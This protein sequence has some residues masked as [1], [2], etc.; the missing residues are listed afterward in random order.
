MGQY[1]LLHPRANSKL[2]ALLK[3][4]PMQSIFFCTSWEDLKVALQCFKHPQAVYVRFSHIAN[5]QPKFYVGSTSSF[6]LDREHSRYRKFLQVQQNK[7]VL[8]E[9][10]LRF[11][12]RFDNFWMWSVFPIYTNKSNFWA[13]EQALIQLWQPRLNTPFIYQF[14]NCRKGL[15]SRTKFSNSRQFGAFSLWRKLRW[16]STPHHLRRALHSPLFH[17]RVQLWEIIQDLGSNSVRRFHMEKRLRS[18]ETGAQGCY[19]IRRLANNLGEPQRSY[20][21][22]AIDRALT[23]WKAKRVRKPVPLRAPWLLAPNWTR[24][25]RQLLTAH[26]H[27]TKC[28]NTALQTPSTGIVFTKFPS[29]MDSLCNHKEAATKWADGEAPKCACGA[30]RQQASHHHQPDQ[31]LVLEGDNLHFEDGPYTSI[32]TGSLQ[33]KI[34]PPS[35]EI[36]ASLRLALRSWTT[37]NS[38]PSLPKTH[39]D[40][41]WHR[42]IHSHYNALHNHITHK[43]IV[44]FKR[45]FPDAIFHN[46][47]K[48]ATSL[49]IY[50]PVLYFQ[51]LTTTFAD[52]LVFRKLEESSSDIIEKTIAEINKQFGKSYPWALGAGRDLPNAYVLPKRKKQFRAGRPIVSFFTA[53]FRPML[54]CIAKLIY[55][56]LPQAFPHNLAKGDVFDLIKLLKDTDFDTF[57]TPRIHNQDLAG[58][59]TSIDTDRFIASWRLTLQFLSTLMSTDPDEII[60]VKATPGNTTG[61]VVKGRTCRTLN[62]TRKIF[63]RDIERIILMSSKMTQFSIG[64]SV[65]E[66]IRG[67]PMGSPLSPALCM[68]VVALSEEI[69]YRTYRTTLTT[70]DLSARLLRYVDNRLCLADPSWDYEICFA[71]FLHPEFYGH[72]IILETEPDQ[73]FLG[74]YRV[75]AFRTPLQPPA[76]RQPG[77][78]PILRITSSGTTIWFR[79][80]TIFGRQMCAPC[81]RTDS[82]FRRIA[83]FVQSSRFLR[84]RF[85]CRCQAY[86]PISTHLLTVVKFVAAPTTLC[87]RL[88]S[89]F[90][91][92]VSPLP[93]E[94]YFTDCCTDFSAGSPSNSF[95]FTLL[96]LFDVSRWLLHLLQ[97]L[98]RFKNQCFFNFFMMFTMLIFYYIEQWPYFHLLSSPTLNP[99]LFPALTYGTNLTGS[100]RTTRTRPMPLLTQS[101]SRHPTSLRKKP[102]WMSCWKPISLNHINM[103]L[104]RHLKPF[105]NHLSSQLQHHHLRNANRRPK[106]FPKYLR[107]VVAFMNI[108]DPAPRAHFRHGPSKKNKN[109]VH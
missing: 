45:L 9:V 62:V 81:T 29:V 85:N 86:S 13:L 104:P 50:C 10:A 96:A 75:R 51:C 90:L 44:R 4:T 24:D 3:G 49:R 79:L 83:S 27:R 76:R 95:P 22:N 54:N 102:L 46:E 65:F 55:N 105:L 72:P 67:S 63:I 48:R 28:Y 36:H 101:T 6:V 89:H 47:D 12:C 94:L 100:D 52:P 2:Q 34:F 80:T 33:N 60:S 23:F 61:D 53:P 7:F 15:I 30:L 103:L 58:F 78:G 56:L 77:H 20:A 8:A 17:R 64:T 88:T 32:A 1:V 99:H 74:F 66:Q 41:L 21:I 19:F 38:L 11:W 108:R 39:L 106:Q 59:F 42:S 69:W 98:F 97:R 91:L 5:F 31:H 40:A 73:E 84:I 26:V 16:Q 68:M 109:F 93:S 37:R 107:S 35:K 70:M 43:D 18:N 71:N 57:P 14:F 82:R 92:D 87:L 25:L